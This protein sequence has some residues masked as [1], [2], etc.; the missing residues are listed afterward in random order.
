MDI[1]SHEVRSRMMREI[2]GKHTAP[3]RAVRS[4][5]HRMGLRFRLH[6]HELPGRPDLV[7]PR[8]RTVLFVHGCFWHRHDC[9]LAATPQTRTEFW[10][11]KFAANV[12]RDARKRTE[13][14]LSGWR[15][16]EIWECETRDP[17]KLS[18]K[19][20]GIFEPA[21]PKV[22]EEQARRQKVL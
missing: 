7:F 2:R 17:I 15:V 19:L 5:A 16:V 9:G 6:V 20:R 12:A 13:L 1:V 8:Y 14:Q 3:E 22:D 10:Q 4:A 21:S 18:I 11:R